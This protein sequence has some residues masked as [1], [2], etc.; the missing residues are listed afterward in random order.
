MLRD[1]P[2]DS[3]AVTGIGIALARE[4]EVDQAIH[5]VEEARG[6]GADAIV[7]VRFTSARSMAGTAEILVYGT[8]VALAD[9]G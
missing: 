1:N 3:Q 9:E 8:A 5:M 7:G 4:G 6:L 2:F